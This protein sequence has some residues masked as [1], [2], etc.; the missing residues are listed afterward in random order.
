MASKTTYKELEQRVKG[1][2][3]K[4]SEHK[5]AQQELQLSEQR[6]SLIYDSV[7]EI[8]YFI[9]VEADDCFRFLSVNHAFLKATGLTSGQIVGKRI[10]E[11]IP[12]TSVQLVLDNYKKAT[13]ENRIVRWQETSVYPAGERICDVSIAPIFNEKGIC[14]HLVGSVHDISENKQAEASLQEAKEFNKA[15]LNSMRAHISVLDRNGVILA[16][17][18]SWKNFAKEN[19]AASMERVGPGANYFEVCERSAS[20]GIVEAQA[21]LDGIQSVIEDRIET[22]ELEYACHSPTEQRWFLMMAVPFKGSERGAIVTH[23]DIT[24]SK[25][26]E[27]EL[28]E[29]YQKITELKNQIEADKIYLQEEIK[30]EH[31]FDQIIGNSDEIKYALFRL[32]QVAKTDSTV[33]ILGET[34]TGK[35]LFARALHSTSRRSERPLIKIDCAALSEQ[36]IESELF[37]HVRGAFTGANESRQGRFELANRGTLFL[38]EIGE[39]PL[40]LQTKLLRVLQDGEFERL[41]DSRTIKTDVRIIAAT[42][43]DIKSFVEAGRFR[44][45]LWYRLNVF[46]ITLPLLRDRKTDIPLLV[47]H[48]VK[49]IGKRIGKEIRS[50]KSLSHMTGRAMYA[51]L[52]M[53]WNDPSSSLIVKT[54]LFMN[55]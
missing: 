50:W 1:L 54:C 52:N 36:L 41:G 8:L 33:I 10:E 35:E 42:N 47:N 44:E 14:T 17:N 49:I 46:P 16:V 45:D 11:V 2:E 7:A 29:A 12:E 31:N 34:G 30:L 9:S 20:A 53:C 25:R 21:A 15:V 24:N 38:D 48:F 6:L 32:E 18:D 55:D 3:K 43:R 27:I 5:V 37:G 23:R 28:K 4:A 22:F 13:K 51:S 40:T 26:S 39:L 19:Q